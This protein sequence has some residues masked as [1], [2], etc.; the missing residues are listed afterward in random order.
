MESSISPKYK[1]D[2]IKK[3]DVKLHETYNNMKEIRSYFE[4]WQKEAEK[5]GKKF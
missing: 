2:L 1:L 5:L 4:L 3:I